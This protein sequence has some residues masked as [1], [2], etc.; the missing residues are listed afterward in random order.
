M[1]PNLTNNSPLHKIQSTSALTVSQAVM[2]LGTWVAF[3]VVGYT[4]L[5]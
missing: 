1:H 5:P 2:V 3:F 4:M